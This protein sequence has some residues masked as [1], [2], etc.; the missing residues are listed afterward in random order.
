LPVQ[1]PMIRTSLLL[2]IFLMVTLFSCKTG[3]QQPTTCNTLATVKD[4]TGLDGCSLL[5]QLDDGTL[6]EPQ[7]TKIGD[8]QLTDGQ[9]ITIDYQIIEDAAS[10]CMTGDHIVNITCAQIVQSP[11]PNIK[12]CHDVTDP[13]TVD[14]LKEAVLQHRPVQVVKYIFRTD[15]WAYLLKGDQCFMYSCQGFLIC[16]TKDADARPC[17]QMADAE[18]RKRGQVIWQS[19][20]PQE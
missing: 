13:M 19:E 10:I 3:N 9:R 7:S 4:Y 6:L 14:W 1:L 8:L 20:G 17:I 16:E 18:S 2:T 12:E 11:I 15:G 5:I